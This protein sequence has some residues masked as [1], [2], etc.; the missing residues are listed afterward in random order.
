MWPRKLLPLEPFRLRRSG[1]TWNAT[2]SQVFS[3]RSAAGSRAPPMRVSSSRS[4]VNGVRT[5]WT[6]KLMAEAFPFDCSK[7][8]TTQPAARATS[9][10]SSVLPSSTTMMRSGGIWPASSS[11]VA[12]RSRAP[13]R[14]AITAVT[15]EGSDRKRRSSARPSSSIRSF[16]KSTS[17]QTTTTQT[18]WLGSWF[19]PGGG[20]RKAEMAI[21]HGLDRPE[22]RS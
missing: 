11:I 18:R 10:V 14:E 19:I 12:G 22:G 3:N 7:R 6:A 1:R 20:P 9:E 13:S 21:R 15:W 17:V 5:R 2:A 8:W 4:R 16:T